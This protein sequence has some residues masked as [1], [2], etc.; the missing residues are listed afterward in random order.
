MLTNRTTGGDVTVEMADNA[1]CVI[2]NNYTNYEIDQ[3]VRNST[4]YLDLLP[5]PIM[6]ARD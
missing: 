6:G 5:I 4:V 3:G 2:I 1:K